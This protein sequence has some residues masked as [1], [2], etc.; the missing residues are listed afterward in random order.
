MLRY[1]SDK[2]FNPFEINENDHQV[3]GD[4]DPILNFIIAISLTKFM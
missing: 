3:F 1:L 2:L 4:I